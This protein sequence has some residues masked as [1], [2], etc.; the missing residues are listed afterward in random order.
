MSVFSIR[1]TAE[2]RSPWGLLLVC[3]SG[4]VYS[5]VEVQNIVVRVLLFLL[6]AVVIF[7][8]GV[9]TKTPRKEDP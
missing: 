5:I 4:A 9:F 3:L 8:I 6:A 1:P 2:A 7:A